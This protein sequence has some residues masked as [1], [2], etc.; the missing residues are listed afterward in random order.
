MQS[1]P[2]HPRADRAG[3]EALCAAHRPFVL[4]GQIAHWPVVQA[5]ALGLEPALQAWAE[6][7]TEAPVDALLGRPQDGR[8][9]GLKPA[10]DGFNFLHSKKPMSAL[11]EAIWRYAQFPDPP[12]LAL[13]SAEVRLCLHDFEAS[14]PMPLLDAAPRL[15]LGN[16]ATVPAH[17]DSSYNLAVCVAGRRRFTLFAPEQI[18]NLYLGP[19]EQAPAQAPISLV[20]VQA[21]DF[22]RFPKA[23]EALANA[24]SA[25]LQPGDAIFM[26]PLWV[27]SVESLE[28]FN[29]LVNYWWR[30]EAVAGAG[31]D[32]PS[33]ALWLTMLSLRHLPAAE[34]RDWQQLFGLL[35]FDDGDWAHIPTERRGLLGEMD[36][37]ALR[38]WRARIRARLLD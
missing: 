31:S 25:E 16:R 2:E 20:N 9:F 12:A 19:L 1:L 33:A 28:P 7:A 17:F 30:P 27:H 18:A 36:A 11:L 21:P 6:L 37:E 26:P 13:Q 4:R 10:L 3:F 22:A 14:H 23:R 5:A 15:W 34:R 29:G 35:A 32:N 8:Q 38:A 24:F